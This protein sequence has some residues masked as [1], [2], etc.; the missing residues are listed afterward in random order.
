MYVCSRYVELTQLSTFEL[1]H[2][3][4]RGDSKLRNTDEHFC[5]STTDFILTHSAFY[6]YV[7]VMV[8]W[9]LE[10]LPQTI[11]PFDTELNS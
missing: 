6:T 3:A 5:S 1:E 7:L 9:F 4:S 10:N 2:S 11:K 8:L